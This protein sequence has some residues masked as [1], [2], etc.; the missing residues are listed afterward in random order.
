MYQ[1]FLS[2]EAEKQRADLPMGV[3]AC[4][5]KRLDE[6]AKDARGGAVKLASI[7]DGWRIR[8]GDY[9]VL[10]TVDDKGQVVRVYRIA[11][12]REVYR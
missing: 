3:K 11:H 7:E 9:R 1:V 5:D 6:L 8:V 10:Y 2:S 4:V 12:R